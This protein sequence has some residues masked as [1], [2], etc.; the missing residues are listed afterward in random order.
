[1]NLFDLFK[2]TLA[3]GGIAF[4]IYS[5]PVLSQAVIIGLLALLWSSYAYKTFVRLT[6]R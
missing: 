3:C 1:M 4:I 6:R 5:Y 2:A